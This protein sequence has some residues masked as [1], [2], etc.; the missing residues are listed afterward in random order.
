ME[1]MLRDDD[2][3]RALRETREGGTGSRSLNDL[4]RALQPHIRSQVRR[5]LPRDRVRR[6]GEDLIQEVNLAFVH[7][8]LRTRRPTVASLLAYINVVVRRRAASLLRRRTQVRE[9]PSRCESVVTIEPSFDTQD[10]AAF[11]L[12]GLNE[13]ERVLMNHVVAGTEREY[14]EQIG[15]KWPA[16]RARRRRMLEQIRSRRSAN[17]R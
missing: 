6:D 8:F 17:P 9:L 12:T 3:E 15:C 13:N 14:A 5:R 1:L 4:V 2:V 7:G 10:D 16:M 11:L